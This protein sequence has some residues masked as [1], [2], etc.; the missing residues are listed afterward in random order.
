MGAQVHIRPW[1]QSWLN[2]ALSLMLKDYGLQ[3]AKKRIKNLNASQRLKDC[4]YVIFQ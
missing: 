4:F 1:A 3:R 2:R